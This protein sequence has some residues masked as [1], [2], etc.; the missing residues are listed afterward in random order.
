MGSRYDQQD[1]RRFQLYTNPEAGT[2]AHWLEHPT[3]GHRMDVGVLPIDFGPTRPFNA[4]PLVTGLGGYEIEE[5]RPTTDVFAV[6]YP[7]GIR[8]GG[9]TAVW[10]R[11]TVA[12]EP[13]ID[14]DDRPCFLI[15]A[16]TR[17]GQSGSPVI[18]YDPNGVVSSPNSLNFHGQ[19]F[20][21]VH[22]VY[23]GRTD[24]QSD[25]GFVWKREAVQEILIHGTPPS[26][27]LLSGRQWPG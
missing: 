14:F 5:L 22:G 24:D 19:P 13:N 25:L 1:P 23:S 11:G 9:F 26:D 16:R 10:V 15:D 7:F 12:S 3:F 21:R 20:C 27:D 8:P 2:G 4:R 17:K 18:E 6:G